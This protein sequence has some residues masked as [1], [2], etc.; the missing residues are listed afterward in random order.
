MSLTLVPNTCSSAVPEPVE[1]SSR[2]AQRLALARRSY[3]GRAA[4]AAGDA[5]S[6]E[7]DLVALLRRGDEAAYETLVRTYG[8]RMLAVARR[9]VPTQ[10]DA[11]DVLQSAFVLVFRFVQ[12]FAGASKLSTWLHRIL[13]NSAL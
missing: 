10:E 4:R 2:R 3:D 11:E 9:Y 8:P 13:V 6:I 12:R 5:E 7:R 1:T